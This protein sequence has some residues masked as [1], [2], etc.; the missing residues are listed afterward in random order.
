MVVVELDDPSHDNKKDEDA[1]RD[2]HCV[3][4]GMRF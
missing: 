4:L 1:K 2:K 3:M